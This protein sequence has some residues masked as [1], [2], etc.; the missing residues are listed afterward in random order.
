VIQAWLWLAAEV[1]SVEEKRGCLK[2]ILQL[3]AEN[4]PASVALPLLDQE[5]RCS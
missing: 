3:G 1:D 2:A 4:E 5:R